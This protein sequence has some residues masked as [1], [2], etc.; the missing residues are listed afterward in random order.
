MFADRL[1]KSLL[2]AAI[3]GQLTKQLPTDGDAR[4]LIKRIR[5][6]K[7]KL[8]ATKKIKAEKPLPP[9]TDDEIPFDIP[10]NWC[11]VHLGDVCEMYTG[12]SIAE[13]EKKSKYL[14]LADGFS[15]ISTKDVSFDNR[16]NY[17]NGVRIPF[18]N[19]FRRACKG[20]VLM[21]IEGGSAGRKIAVTDHDVCFGNKLCNFNADKISNRYIYF[22]L[23]S[24]AF[25]KIFV[26][27]MT[28]IIGG[29]SLRRLNSIPFP[30]PPFAEQERIVE[31]LDALLSEVDELTKDE[32]EFVALEETFPRRMR[33]SLL[34]AAI[35]GQLTEQLPT[36]GDARDLIKKIRA[37]K[38]KLLA[39]KKIKAEKPLP[40]ITDDEIPFDLPDNWCWCRLGEVCN[41]GTNETILPDAMERGKLL[42]DLED[43]E[44]DSGNLVSRKFFNGNNARSSKNI[45]R[46]GQ[47]LF[48]KLRVYLNKVIVADEDGYCSSEILPLDFGQNI[49]SRYAQIV[50]NRKIIPQMQDEY[51]S[52][53]A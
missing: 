8:I 47:V 53:L 11:W 41:Y 20:S 3:Q 44:K 1:K 32:R 23:Q 24:P 42:I 7:A 51:D 15:Y 26:D 52:R 14:G 49:L 5:A 21:C 16:I 13:T 48:G 6:E 39:A 31:K 30:L 45:F 18:E 12:D 46:R 28:G 38:A 25:K 17:D 35:Q 22:Y 50:L 43:I 27:N 10:D 37:E 4:D 40:P 2:Q 34:Q 19:T 9:V 36:D 29:V 33:N